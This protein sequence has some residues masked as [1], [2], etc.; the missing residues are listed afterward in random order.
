[1]KWVFFKKR[2]NSHIWLREKKFDWSR[3]WREK[4]R[5]SKEESVE[6]IG[7]HLSFYIEENEIKSAYFSDMPMILLVYKETYFNTN[8]CDH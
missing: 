6:N 2:E 3:E 4:I 7:K 5:M 1:M 8:D